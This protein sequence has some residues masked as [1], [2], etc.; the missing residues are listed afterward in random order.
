MN[1]KVLK[2]KSHQNLRNMNRI[3]HLDLVSHSWCWRHQVHSQNLTTMIHHCHTTLYVEIHTATLYKFLFLVTKTGVGHTSLTK[4]WKVC[5]EQRISLLHNF[6][7]FFPQTR[8]R[9]QNNENTMAKVLFSAEKS[10][11]RG[12][13]P[14]NLSRLDAQNDKLSSPVRHWNFHGIAEVLNYLWHLV[15][16]IKI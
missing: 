15:S 11:G 9:R 4:H 12:T 13:W 16:K 8:N 6:S 7:D 5:T 10:L 1:R 14:R 3:V 2:T